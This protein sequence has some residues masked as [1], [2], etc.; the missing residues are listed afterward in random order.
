MSGTT[1]VFTRVLMRFM[2]EPTCDGRLRRFM[3]E[4]YG[5]MA[6]GTPI[7]HPT[8][9]TPPFYIRCMSPQSHK[10]TTDLRLVY[11]A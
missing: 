11:Y 1:M 7:A 3:W 10:S 6:S 5:E 4:L 2:R 9:T 8:I